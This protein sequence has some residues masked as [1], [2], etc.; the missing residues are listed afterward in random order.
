[1]ALKIPG[2]ED[3]ESIFESSKESGEGLGQRQTKTFIQAIPGNIFISVDPELEDYNREGGK[4][5]NGAENAAGYMWPLILK[6]GTT[7]TRAKLISNTTVGLPLKLYTSAPF[8]TLISGAKNVWVD[9]NIV[10]DETKRYWFEIG[11]NANEILTKI[12]FEYNEA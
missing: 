5:S 8:D 4:I 2:E 6:K 10:I 3:G 11:L 7:I 9:A 1:M 12:D